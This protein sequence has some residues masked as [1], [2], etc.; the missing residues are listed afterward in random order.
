[1]LFKFVAG[2]SFKNVLKK[3]NIILSKNKIPIKN[4]HLLILIKNISILLQ[5]NAAIEI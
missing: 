2:N 1:M 4:Y 3:S 5:K